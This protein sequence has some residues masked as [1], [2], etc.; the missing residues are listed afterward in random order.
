MPNVDATLY[1]GAIAKD[2][3]DI[4]E[5]VNSVLKE[6]F[7]NCPDLDANLDD[8]LRNQ[9]DFTPHNRN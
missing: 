3:A 8:Y 2:T 4:R 1:E 7:F 5:N 6:L 9:A